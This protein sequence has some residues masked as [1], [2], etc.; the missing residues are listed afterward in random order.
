MYGDF[1]ATP[2]P[3]SHPYR[4]GVTDLRWMTMKLRK[5]LSRP[6]WRTDLHQER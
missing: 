2:P 6:H 1:D 4:E 3:H 5:E